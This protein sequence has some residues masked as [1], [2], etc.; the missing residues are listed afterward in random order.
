A[1]ALLNTKQQA[2]CAQSYVRY[3]RA[4]VADRGR[5][6][7]EGRTAYDL[8][9]KSDARTPGTAMA[10]HQHLAKNGNRKLAKAILREHLSKTGGDGHPTS[11]DLYNRLNAGEKVSLIVNTVEEG[12]AE[13]FYGLGEALTGE[14]GV[15]I[16]ALY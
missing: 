15:S 5:R 1:W 8:V 11:R 12:M 13:V 14:G 2:V 6:P 9:I 7:S 16:G 3:H 10:Y 4:L